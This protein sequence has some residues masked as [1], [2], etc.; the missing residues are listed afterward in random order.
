M[1]KVTLHYDL[2]RPLGDEDFENIAPFDPVI[3][4][5]YRRTAARDVAFAQQLLDAGPGQI[6]QRTGQDA[7]KTMPRL[8][9]VHRHLIL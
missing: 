1:T 5:F 2:T 9:P 4:V 7:V 8:G 6:A 3:G